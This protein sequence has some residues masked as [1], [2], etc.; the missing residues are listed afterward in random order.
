MHH[1]RYFLGFWFFLFSMTAFSASKPLPADEAFQFSVKVRDNQTIL[2]IWQITPSYY[3]YRARI[4]FQVLQPDGIR[5]SQ[6]LM[7]DGEQKV[8]P[9]IGNY[10]VYQGLLTIPLPIINPPPENLL[11]K[12]AYQGCS[13]NGYCYPPTQKIVSVNMSGPYNQSIFPLHIDI[14]STA[15]NTAPGQT[16]QVSNLF[17]GKSLLW[18]TLGF[19][20]LGLLISLTPCVLP[21]IPILSAIIVGQKNLTHQRAFGVSLAYVFGMALTYSLAGAAFGYFGELAQAYFQNPWVL[22]AFSLVFILM[23]LSMFGFYNIELPNAWRSKIAITSEHQK[24]GS[25]FGAFVMGILS[26]LILSPCV[27]APLVAVLAYISHTGN[28]LLGALALFTMGIGMGAPLLALGALGPKL[29]PKAGAWMNAVK[30]LLGF[31]LLFMAVYLLSRVLSG[32]LTLLFYALLCF[33]LSIY[34]GAFSTAFSWKQFTVKIIGVL[35]F[36][37]SIL[38]SIGAYFGNGNP[39]NPLQELGRQQSK[40]LHFINIKNVAD[41]ENQIELAKKSNTP[42]ML[43]FYA[44]WCVACKTMDHFTFSNPK[45]IAALSHYL[46]LRADVTENNSEDRALERRFNVVA[47]PTILF[48]QK[49]EEIQ[50]ARI[51]GEVSA[52]A[53][54]KQLPGYFPLSSSILPPSRQQLPPTA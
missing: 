27:T 25:Y 2:A 5:L 46:L 37:G 4:H 36:I 28:A 20:G 51:I 30:I 14:P 43:D 8:S 11:L 12:V 54:L 21:M 22:G 13:I 31:L 42:V 39:L 23:A 48:F 17:E 29:L 34:L 9:E 38:L 33:I 6:P 32:S 24:R 41:A 53:F 26:T 3:L 40:G 45:V 50:K 15:T 19:L 10:E 18:F 35:F 7:P 47:P 44:D 16:E 1:L 52:D 49:G